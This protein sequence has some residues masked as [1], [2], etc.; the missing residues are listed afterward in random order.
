LGSAAGMNSNFAF[1]G[2]S[3]GCLGKVTK[4]KSRWRDSIPKTIF[5]RKILEL[6]TIDDIE[7]LF[8]QHRA[9]LP[10]HHYIVFQDKAF[11]IQI[12]PLGK[13]FKKREISKQYEFH[14]NHFI[15]DS[16]WKWAAEGKK[17]SDDRYEY[18]QDS[19]RNGLPTKQREQMIENIVKFLAKDKRWEKHTSATL[20]FTISKTKHACEGFFYFDNPNPS[21]VIVE[22]D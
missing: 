4:L 5:S 21:S 22:I 20:L 16:I 6:E 12:R 9:T 13:P 2:N 17:D 19:L 11:S 8:N 1:Q 15:D 7:E 3:I 18:L 10:N 14:T